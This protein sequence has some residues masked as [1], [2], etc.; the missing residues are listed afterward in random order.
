MG[1][2]VIRASGLGKRYRLGEHPA[3]FG[4]LRDFV[5]ERLAARGGGRRSGPQEIVWALRDVDLEVREGE[6]LGLIGRNG[7]GKT[8]LLKV[9]SRITEPTT[10]RVELRGRVGSL[11][12]VG[13]GFHPELTGRENVYL[14]GAILGMGRRE[15]D[16]KLDEIVAF[17][18]VETFLDTPVKRYSSGM[19]LRLAF[20]VAAHLEPEI[21]LVDEILAVGDAEFRRRCLAKMDEVAAGGRTVLF[22]SHNL[23]AVQRL[24]R[25]SILLDRGRIV[26]DGPTADT[27]RSYGELLGSEADA[28]PSGDGNLSLRLLGVE[29]MGPQGIEAGEPFRVDLAVAVGEELPGV[30]L[31]ITLRDAADRLIVYDRAEGDDV[32]PL[33]R[34]GNHRV[35]VELPALWLAPGLYSLGAKL[36]GDRFLGPK[37]RCVADPLLIQVAS[38]GLADPTWPGAVRPVGR[39]TIEAEATKR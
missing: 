27:T 29:P 2:P 13:T 1:A 15:I 5:G 19:H 37:E 35:S 33:G 30:S 34:P 39:W 32:E 24:C 36:I 28:A 31:T 38:A 17:S 7:S 3:L 26:A 11:L 9:L 22:V 4:S 10:G 12:E 6:V 21:L 14:S 16:R 18:G 20:S 23:A 8:T 25:R